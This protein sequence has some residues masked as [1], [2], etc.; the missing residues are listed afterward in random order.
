MVAPTKIRSPWLLAS[1]AV[2]A[3]PKKTMK[4]PHHCQIVRTRCMRKRDSTAAQ[5]VTDE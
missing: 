2:I 5:I 1:K 3:R 4:M